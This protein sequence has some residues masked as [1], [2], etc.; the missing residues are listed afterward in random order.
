L[1]VWKQLDATASSIHVQTALPGRGWNERVVVQSDW[2]SLGSPQLA[3]GPDGI[4]LAWPA[5]GAGTTTVRALSLDPRGRPVGNPVVVTSNLQ[6]GAGV[7]VADDGRTVVVTPAHAALPGGVPVTQVAR[8]ERGAK[9]VIDIVVPAGWREIG[10][11]VI[12]L[13]APLLAVPLGG[14]RGRATLLEPLDARW[15]RRVV[16]NGSDGKVLATHGGMSALRVG[17]S[18]QAHQILLEPLRR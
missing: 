8:V 2:G 17:G 12:V 15:R 7:A 16:S 3:A 5:A 10:P 18:R 6:E 13:G 11:A 14:A 4:T 9:H 1:V